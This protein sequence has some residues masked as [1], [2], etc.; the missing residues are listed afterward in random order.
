MGLQTCGLNRNHAQK[1]LQPHG[2]VEFPCAA[3]ASRHTDV[4]WPCPPAI[5]RPIPLGGN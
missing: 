4:P 2:T 5:P 1:E 3:Y